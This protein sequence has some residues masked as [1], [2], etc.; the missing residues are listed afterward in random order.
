MTTPEQIEPGSFYVKDGSAHHVVKVTS[1]TDT[2][3]TFNWFGITFTKPK[4]EFSK[5]YTYISV[6]GM[7]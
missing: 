6:P 3:V 5:H 4:E 2:D 1:V 7:R